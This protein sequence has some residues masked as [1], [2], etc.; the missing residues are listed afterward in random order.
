MAKDPA[1][2]ADGVNKR[3]E[4]ATETKRAETK[5]VP[6]KENMRSFLNSLSIVWS[7]DRKNTSL[8]NGFYNVLLDLYYTIFFVFGFFRCAFLLS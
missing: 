6:L 3:L 8:V 4:K 5:T 7:T 1:N 2:I